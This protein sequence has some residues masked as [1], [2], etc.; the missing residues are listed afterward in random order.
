MQLLMRKYNNS[1]AVFVIQNGLGAFDV[2]PCADDYY[3]R[4]DQSRLEQESEEILSNFFLL[5]S[6]Y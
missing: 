2:C 1:T 6:I 4:I 3:S 5:Y